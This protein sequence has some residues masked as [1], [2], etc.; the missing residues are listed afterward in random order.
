VRTHTLHG[1]G[2]YVFNRNNPSIHTENG[3]EVPDTQGVR[4]HH[5]MTVNLGAGTIDHVVN[6]VGEAAD[7]TRVGAP[8][9]V[10]DYP[11]P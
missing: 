6:G 5:I 10:L 4:L 11:A 9:Y 1:G 2:V 8:V 3:F 7:T